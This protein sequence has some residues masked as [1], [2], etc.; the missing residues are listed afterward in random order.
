M[1]QTMTA[2]NLYQNLKQ[3][4]MEERQ[5]FFGILSANAFQNEDMSHE[6]LFGQLAHDIFTAAEAMEYLEV[7]QST[8]RRFVA[9]KKLIPASTVGRSQMFAVPELKAF[10]KALKMAK[11]AGRVAH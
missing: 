1:P 7:S 3:M 8:F 5:K 11:G 9:N 6:Q 4:P 2:E 10:K